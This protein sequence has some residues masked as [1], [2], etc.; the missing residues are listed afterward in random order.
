MKITW[1]GHSAFRLDFAD[2]VVLIDPFFT[3]NPAFE[4]R[5]EKASEGS[6]HIL[7]TH[8]HGD[9]VG[10]SLDHR[11]GNR[12]QN[13]RECGSGRLARVAGPRCR[14]DEYGRHDGSGRLYR[15]AGAGGPFG[16]ARR[17]GRQH[18][19]RERQ[20]R[21]R[22]GAGRTDDL[23]YGRHGHLRRHGADRRNPPAGRGDRAYRRPFHHGPAGRGPGG[24]A[25]F[26]W[27]EGGHSLSLR[28]VLDARA[29]TRTNS[30]PRSTAR[31]CRWWCRTRPWVCA[32]D[33]AGDGRGV[34]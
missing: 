26:R 10:D 5:A 20:R 9:H 31:E 32:S 11:E 25:V 29:R 3:G 14:P 4:G 7:I 22:Q 33:I 18:A 19:G 21:H 28:L 27:G 13:R 1:F 24:R 15:H 23:P 6:T 30:W 12:R 16:G 34:L 17:N 2:K 8:G